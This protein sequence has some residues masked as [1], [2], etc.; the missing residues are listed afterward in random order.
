MVSKR[1]QW[2][3]L[4]DRLIF[5]THLIC[6]DLCNVMR[7]L[8]DVVAGL[9][10]T[11]SNIGGALHILRRTKHPLLHLRGLVSNNHRYVLPLHCLLLL[12]SAMS[13]RLHESLLRLSNQHLIVTSRLVRVDKPVDPKGL[14]R[15]C[16]RT[17]R[18]WKACCN[19]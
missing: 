13:T 9:E 10:A 12:S 14:I 4:L 16:R 6:S 19:L 7:W 3:R 17:I 15:S 1:L 2:R 18:R 5:K 8:I 11:L